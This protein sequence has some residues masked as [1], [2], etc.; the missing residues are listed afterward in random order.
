[1]TSSDVFWITVFCYCSLAEREREILG[2]STVELLH[3]PCGVTLV[4]GPPRVSGR[5]RLATDPEKVTG[6]VFR[7]RFAQRSWKFQL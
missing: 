5:A 2:V 7:G 3:V 1:M 6:L 4:L